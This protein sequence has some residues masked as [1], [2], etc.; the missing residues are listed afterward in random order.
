MVTAGSARFESTKKP[1]CGLARKLAFFVWIICRSGTQWVRPISS[2]PTSPS[3]F[4]Y[5]SQVPSMFCTECG[6]P[7]GAASA[8]KFCG[9]CGFPVAA[10]LERPAVA[11]E[12][13]PDWEQ[14]VRYEQ[15]L[16]YPHVRLLI[17][18]HTRLA[19][20]RMTGEQFLALADKLIPQPV[21]MEGLAAV[22]QTA[23]AKLG[24]RT[25][26]HRE[27]RI[28]APV[29]E[30]IVRA[31]CSL[32]RHGQ[33]LRNVTQAADGCVLEASLPSDLLS[34]QGDLLVTI[35]RSALSQ[36]NQHCPITVVSATASIP[37]QWYDWGKNSRSL[38]NLFVDAATAAILA[39]PVTPLADLRD[40]H[41]PAA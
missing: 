32:A 28:A 14:E 24:I 23:F 22:T 16:Q 27:E 2:R 31:L 19:K 20:Q 18:Q 13:L 1:V 10:G 9:H 8:G 4:F 15:L 34:L 17:E 37:G 12:V 39:E 29:G 7:A 41:R 11:A 26:K 25:D 38:D 30:I 5:A 40:R 33:K 6:Q 3:N 35:R 36:A 21:S